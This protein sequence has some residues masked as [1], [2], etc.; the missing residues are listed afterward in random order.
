[1][2]DRYTIRIPPSIDAQMAGW[3]LPDGHAELIEAR[4]RDELAVDPV[5]KLIRVVGMDAERLNVFSFTIPSP[6]VPGETWI[7]AFHFLY[8]HDEKHL[9]MVSAECE[10][11]DPD[12]DDSLTPV[13]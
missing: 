12:V 1:M 6:P 13:M 5:N 4:L 2:P 3:G 9:L 10:P 8:S 7:F 11:P